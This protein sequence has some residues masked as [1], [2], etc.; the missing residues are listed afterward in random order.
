MIIPLIDNVRRS[1]AYFD[2]TDSTLGTLRNWVECHDATQ[3]FTD[4]TR[5]TPVSADAQAVKGLADKSGKASH[6][7]QS[8]TGNAPLYKTGQIGNLPCLRFT[9]ASS[10][11]MTANSFAMTTTGT[12]YVLMKFVTLSGTS[13]LFSGANTNSYTWKFSA[14]G[15]PAIDQTATANLYTGV[16]AHA[17]N[18]YRV[19]AFSHDGAY[20]R[21]YEDGVCLAALAALATTTESGGQTHVGADTTPANYLGADV[22]SWRMYDTVAHSAGQVL[23]CSIDMLRRAGLAHPL[24]GY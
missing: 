12:F 9:K 13:V 15:V 11:Y 22:G 21:Y 4:T 6:W 10:H 1:E 14:A 23:A 17:T 24:Y 3:M 19:Y 5:T 18:A 2:P 20:I 7:S 16:L 8:T